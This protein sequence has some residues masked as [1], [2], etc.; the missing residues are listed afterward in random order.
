MSTQIIENPLAKFN[1]FRTNDIDDAHLKIADSVSPHSVGVV[2]SGR[3]LDV[4]FTGLHVDDM[5]MVGVHY[6][7]EVEVYPEHSDYYFVQTTLCGSGLVKHGKEEYQT[8]NGNTAVVSPSVPYKMR[9]NKGCQRLAI[10]IKPAKLNDYLSTLINDDVDEE[11]VFDLKLTNDIAWWNTINYVATQICGSAQ[12]LASKELQKVYSKLIV[13]SLLELHTHN[14]LSKMNAKE[15]QMLS[16]QIRATIDYIRQNVKTTITVADLAEH[17]KVSLRTLQRN[18][19][20]YTNTPPAKFIRD[21]KLDAIHEELKSIKHAE[22]GTVKRVLLDHNICDFG[23]LA[24]YY[25]AKFG[26]TPKETLQGN[27]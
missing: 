21:A 12:V 17:S 11:L 9:L 7:A 3:S 2:G 20:K 6:G 14:Y 4:N 16:P 26:C 5:P 15:D 24:Q 1:L 22:C 23:R 19:L 25:R 10:G 8:C 27:G 18:F 13:S